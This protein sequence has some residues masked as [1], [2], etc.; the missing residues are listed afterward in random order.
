MLDGSLSPAR[1]ELHARV[2][3][4]GFTAVCV[5]L[6]GDMTPAAYRRELEDAGLTPAPG[7]FNFMTADA[8]GHDAA[9]ER[10]KSL[11][12]AHAELGLDV[13]YLADD[14]NDTRIAEPAEGSHFDEQ[15]FA[16]VVEGIARVAEAIRAEGLAPAFH[17]HIGTWVESE[18][19]IRGLL[20]AVGADIL[21]LGPDTGH[22]TWAGIDPV[23]FVE[24]FGSRVVSLHLKDVH[25]AK[26]VDAS[27][28]YFDRVRDG[29]LTEPGRGDVDNDAV[30]AALPDDF[31]GWVIIE[32]DQPDGLTADESAA[33][34]FAWVE[35]RA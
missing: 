11:A 30:L 29:L 23:A 21:S 1:D 35:A 10:A 24:E 17:Q 34:S 26:L 31:D 13:L 20:D 28:S 5:N 27:G 18:R 12:A 25:A 6:P 14:G 2:A 16:T 22:L 32:V 3:A 4:S 9:V 7:Y 15:R 19:E 33:R 8:E